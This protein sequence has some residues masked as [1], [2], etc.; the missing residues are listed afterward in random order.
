MG[1]SFLA[2][3]QVG[4][5]VSVLKTIPVI[6]AL[7]LWARLMTWVDKDAPAA[8]LPRTAI[9][10]ANLGGM[11][12]GFFL[13]MFLPGYVIAFAA[14][15]FIMLVE[16]GVYL[17]IRSRHVGL[18]DLKDQFNDWLHS[19]KREKKHKEL[20]NQVQIIDKSGGV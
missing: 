9:N 14:F 20:P 13:L 17:G 11:I 7:L 8:H 2:E 18:A 3:V 1:L 4:G 16:A 6:L 15:L 12:L 19:F 10:T 5:Y